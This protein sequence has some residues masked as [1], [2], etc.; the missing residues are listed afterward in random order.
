MPVDGASGRLLQFFDFDERRLGNREDLPMHWSKV[1]GPGLP[2]YVNGRLVRDMGRSSGCSFRFDLNGGSLVYRTDPTLLPVTRGGRYRV[3]TYVKTTQFENAR[4]R[5]SVTFYDELKRPIERSTRHSALFAGSGAAA[6]WTPLLVEMR[7]ADPRAAYLSVDMELLQPAFYAPPSLGAR[8]LFNQDVTGSAWFTDL[9]VMQVPEVTI[10]SDAMGN[11]FGRTTPV[12][13]RLRISD[14]R[15]NDLTMRLEIVDGNGK[16]VHQRTGPLDLNPEDKGTEHLQ[17]VAVPELPAG[18]YQARITLMSGGKEVAWETQNFVRLA[19]DGSPATPDPRFGIVA[20]QLLPAQWQALPTLLPLLGAGRVKVT[21]WSEDVD[22]GRA[23]ADKFDRLLEQ[24][25]DGGVVPTAC[26]TGIPSDAVPSGTSLSRIPKLAPSVWQPRLN[27]IIA[28]HASHLDRWQFGPDEEEHF[29]TDKNFRRAYDVTYESFKAL[30]HAPDVA[31]PW[32]ATYEPEQ[33]LPSTVALALPPSVLPDQIPLYVEDTRDR[34]GKKLSLTLLPLGSAY[35][36]EA[37][38][39]D[40]AQRMVMSLVGGAERIDLPLPFTPDGQPSEDFVV[41]RTCAQALGGAQYR[42]RLNYGDKAEALLFEKGGRGTIALWSKA[43]IPVTRTDVMVNLGGRPLV[44]DLFGNVTPLRLAIP[45]DESEPEAVKLAL[46]P[47]P[48]FIEGVDPGMAMFKVSV[49]VDNPLLES[50]VNAQSRQVMFTNTLADYLEGQVK[51]VPPEGWTVTPST[52]NIALSPGEVFRRPVQIT[53]PYSA[54]AGDKVLTLR[55]TLA[56][57]RPGKLTV[58]VD[59]KLGL[60]DVGMQGLAIVEGDQVVVQLFVTNYSQK[61]LNYNSFAV[62]PGQARQEL[63]I[64]NLGPGRT[65]VKRFR[66]P[67][68]ATAGKAK[69]RVG[70]REIEGTRTLNDEVALPQATLSP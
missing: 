18:W 60:A 6:E 16:L 57:T 36:R 33:S 65:A 37:E 30:M 26:I 47:L 27:Y 29:A 48:V 11:I 35:G 8:T 31:I 59:L 2:H 42:G 15:A 38:L 40:Y 45:K 39:R 17:T 14:Q 66:F 62:C 7:S 51:L 49:A 32:P 54:I 63:L 13:L 50:S 46:G 53:M 56:G 52:F 70:L 58:P 22:I 24:L 21:A 43:S 1:E 34:G 19:D 5:I 44:T 12:R 20:E 25:Q 61:V 67:A 68:S 28:R 9:S 41:L 55:F 10:N 64:T 3:Q 4:A 23:D 69:L